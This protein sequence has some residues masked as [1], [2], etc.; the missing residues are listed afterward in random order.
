M[1]WREKKVF[2]TGIDGFVGSNIAKTMLSEGAI[3]SGL[4]HHQTPSEKSCLKA[5]GL[6]SQID[7][8]IGDITDS[9][10]L[11]ETIKNSDPQW[12]FHLA[13]QA[14]VSKAQSNVQ[15]TIRTNIQ[16]TCNLIDAASN[17]DK[18]SGVIIASSDK[19]YGL[20]SSLPYKEETPLRGG[21]IYDSSK[22]C[23]DLLAQSLAKAADLPLGITRC[24]N[25][26]GPGDLNLSRIIPDIITSLIQKRPLV[27]RNTG[28]QKRDF[29][30]IEDAVSA[31]FK[32][33]EYTAEH[34]IRGEAFNFGTGKPIEIVGL[35]NHIIQLMD[36]DIEKPIISGHHN[37]YEIEEQYVD[38][39]K[40]RDLFGWEPEVSLLNGL[41]HTI[42]WY[43][44]F[45]RDKRE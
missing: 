20:S 18:L 16:G 2:I 27:I 22:A 1:Q 17:L 30:Y 42:K 40:A 31:Y 36:S 29:L 38:A 45:L 26:Y 37:S 34:N 23:A 3:V 4:I 15:D 32:L 13:A 7:T 9:V 21:G 25:I 44:H 35:V 33:A 10:S 6:T 5:W 12:I 11:K 24:S 28:K 8:Y 43:K 14:I 19:A 39:S 41:K